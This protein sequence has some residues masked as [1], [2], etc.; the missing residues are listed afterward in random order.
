MVDSTVLHIWNCANW[1][2][3]DFSNGSLFLQK[4][5]N[6]QLVK[7]MQSDSE[8]TVENNEAAKN[9]SYLKELSKGSYPISSLSLKSE[10]II[11]DSHPIS[12]YG[13]V[14]ETS[15]PTASEN[16]YD[17]KSR[18]GKS[19]QKTTNNKVVKGMHKWK[20]YP[21][22]IEVVNVVMSSYLPATNT[23]VFVC[24]SMVVH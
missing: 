12:T 22:L 17:W 2:H 24:H 8:D 20:D 5:T 11:L 23:G 3:N 19:E 9:I 14:L 18:S 4:Q 21:E 7:R 16:W 1:R 15:Y 6:V 10:N 13:K